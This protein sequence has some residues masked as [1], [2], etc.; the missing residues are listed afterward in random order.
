[1]SS[2]TPASPASA[3]AGAHRRCYRH[4]LRLSQFEIVTIGRAPRIRQQVEQAFTDSG[5]LHD[6]EGDSIHPRG[7]TTLTTSTPTVAV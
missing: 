1:M 5:N 2:E 7:L 4:R 6:P 3:G